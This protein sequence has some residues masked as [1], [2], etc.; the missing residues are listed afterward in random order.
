[1]SR[2]PRRKERSRNPRRF[3][4]LV[5]WGRD[6]RVLGDYFELLEGPFTIAEAESLCRECHRLGAILASVH[7]TSAARKLFESDPRGAR[8]RRKE[9]FTDPSSPTTEGGDHMPRVIEVIVTKDGQTTVQ[10]KG[11]RGSTCTDASKWLEQALGITTNDRKT[12]EFYETTMTDQ[13]VQ[14]S[15]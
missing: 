13:Q 3:S 14:Q 9:Q 11:Y 1:M 5:D 7:A 2:P 10:T 6:H 4:V 8:A 12:N 15:E